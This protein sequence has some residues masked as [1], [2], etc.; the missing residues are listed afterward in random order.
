MKTGFVITSSKQNYK[1]FRNQP[2]GALYLQTIME[3]E[4]GKNLEVSLL[5]LRA[6]NPDDAIYHVPEKDIYMYSITTLD[7]PDTERIVKEIRGIYPKA[8][9]IAGGPHVEI[10]QKQSLN[11]FDAISL[12]EGEESIKRIIKDYSESNLKRIYRQ[13]EDIDISRYPIAS[14]K[15]LPKSAVVDK[16]LLGKEYLNLNGTAALFS[17][18]CPFDCHFCSNLNYGKTKFRSPELIKKE[19][20]YL[21]KEYGIEALAIKDDNS[22]PVNRKTAQPFLEAIAQTGIKW[23]GQSR[24]NGIHSDMV[25]L[26]K[27]SGCT[28][29]AVGIESISEKVLKIINKHINFVQAKK[30]LKQLK[31]E[32]IDRRL[33]LITGLPGEPDNIVHKTI[34]FIKEVEPSSVLL[35][36]FCPLP[37]SEI[38][39]NPQKFGIKINE[40][41]DFDKYITAFGRF[42]ENEKPKAVFE[43]EKTTPFG[44]GK[45]MDKILEDHM[46]IQTFL[47][48]NNLIF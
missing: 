22:I 15:Y 47:K 33:L 27:E 14:R 35:S 3:E 4:F 39:K 43:Y 30:Y 18:G 28:E 44:K 40:K 29:I 37:G 31:K 24:A 42:D 6:I 11:T 23:R 13:Q 7:Y 48:E 36:L 10:F 26:A 9:H 12:G 45:S 5:D 1:P 34:N 41:M 16:S 21:K 20:N 2:L 8:K 19:I 38:H 25:K 46:K 32:G 17:R